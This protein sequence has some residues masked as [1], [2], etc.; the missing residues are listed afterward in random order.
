M[1][2]LLLVLGLVLILT[3]A[4]YLVDGASAIAKRAGLSD[5]I[6]GMTIVG[7]GTSTPEMVVSFASAIKGNADIA[8][9]NVLGSNIFNT[10]M[11]LGATALFSP[12]RLTSNNVKKDIPFALLAAFVLC[13][14]GC[15]TWLD[16]TA[17]N[18]ISRVSG[19]LLLSL[20]GVFMAYT[21]YSSSSQGATTDN[22]DNLSGS[23]K[24][25]P[26]W[27]ASLMIL[28]GLCGLVFGGD[29]FV[30][31]A[32]AIAKS[33]GVSDAV[34]A[35]TI[36]AGGTSLPELASCLVAAYKK[37]T[38]QALGNVI[39][40]NV[41]NI[42]L[43]LGGSATIH[44]LVMAGTKPLDLITLMV[45]SILIFLFA[46]TFKKKQIDRIEGAL[47]VCLYIAFVVLTLRAL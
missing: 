2:I 7:I 10:L 46:F 39:G 25:A 28:G 1:D 37:N 23:K 16:G 6:I 19:I 18:T 12:I 44:P 11:I 9:G 4:N 29:M 47:L 33:L 43:I 21:I 26:I 45:S 41:S 42:F 35:V 22:P 14:F 20:F 34:I 5:F 32:S 13:T 8:V 3:G 17:V 27:L 24:T 40:S 38:D 30:N 31:A 36:V 15:S